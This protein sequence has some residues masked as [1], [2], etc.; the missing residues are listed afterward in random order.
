VAAARACNRRLVARGVDLGAYNTTE[1]AADFADLRVAL[2][3]AEWNVFGVSYGTNLA[4]TLMRQHP[5]GIRSVTI[6][7]VEPPEVVTAGSFAPNGREGFDRL[8][9]A[10]TAQPQCW[11]R[12]PGIARTFTNL[13]RRL[14]A[15]PVAV[16]VKPPAGGSRVKVVLDGGRLVDWLYKVA[17]NTPHYR[18]VP[19]MI[20][21]LADGHPRRIASARAAPILGTPPGIVGF[22]LALGV[23]CA[24][25]VPYQQGS[26]LSIGRRAFPPIRTRCS[27]RPCTCRTCPTTAA[28]GRFRRRPLNSGRQRRARSRPCCSRAASTPSRRRVGRG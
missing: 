6:D 23:G 5:Q 3:I 9:R 12:R 18:D 4:M 16:R 25:W 15:H 14:E 27:R 11:R 20:A 21:E 26:I 19:A 7:S 8:F 2:G 10:C 17:F 1:N 13:V 24:E 28:C 22:G